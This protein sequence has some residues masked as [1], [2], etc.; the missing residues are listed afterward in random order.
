MLILVPSLIRQKKSTANPTTANSDATPTP[1]P[2][3]TEKPTEAPKEKK[4]VVYDFNGKDFDATVYTDVLSYQDECVKAE[5]IEPPPVD[6]AT[7]KVYGATGTNLICI[8]ISFNEEL[9]FSQL[10]SFVVRMKVI[11]NASHTKD[12]L[13]RLY[14]DKVNEIRLTR[15]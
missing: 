3:P 7:G 6:G 12:P 5:L 1:S 8:G 9:E 2:V 4:T 13:V 14:D 11:E 10:E 15:N